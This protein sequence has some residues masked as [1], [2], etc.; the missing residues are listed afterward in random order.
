MR[1]FGYTLRYVTWN[2]AVKGAISGA[3]WSMYWMWADFTGAL[4]WPNI[5]GDLVAWLAIGVIGGLF[6]FLVGGFTGLATSAGY[7]VANAMLLRNFRDIVGY[8]LSLTLVGGGVSFFLFLW[9]FGSLGE[10]IWLLISGA[11][12]AGVGVG[13]TTWTYVTDYAD[14]V[15]H[16]RLYDPYRD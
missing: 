8:R 1:R 14:E 6:G 10:Q 5:V 11:A 12:L 16:G 7:A 3:L 4:I 13:V 2:V 9:M 15:L